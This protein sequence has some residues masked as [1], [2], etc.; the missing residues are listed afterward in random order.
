MANAPE[1]EDK[2]TAALSR[3]DFLFTIQKLEENIAEQIHSA[4]HAASQPLSSELKSITEILSEVAQAAES[5]LESATIA[6][7][8]IQRL[9][10]TEDWSRTKIMA[11][12]NKLRERNLKFCGI[13]EQVEGLCLFAH[14]LP[15]SIK[16]LNALA[17]THDVREPS[18]AGIPD[19]Q[20]DKKAPRWSQ[21]KKRVPP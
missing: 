5:A 14:D 16:M 10:T 1:S 8:N 11:I 18:P 12:E 15:S 20:Q 3:Q 17:I 21:A 13:V 4:I 7:E 2:D 9:Q 6:Q 19:P